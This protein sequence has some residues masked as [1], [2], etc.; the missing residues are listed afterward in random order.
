MRSGMPRLHALQNVEDNTIILSCPYSNVSPNDMYPFLSHGEQHS[1]D[2]RSESEN[3]SVSLFASLDKGTAT[4]NVSLF[5][6]HPCKPTSLN[7]V[8]PTVFTTCLPL[9]NDTDSKPV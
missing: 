2:F 4:F 7:R 6:S 9:A 5:K 8:I 1:N 3:I